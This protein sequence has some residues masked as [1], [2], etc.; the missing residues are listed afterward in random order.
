MTTHQRIIKLVESYEAMGEHFYQLNKMLC[1]LATDVYGEGY[2]SP[3][4]FLEFKRLMTETN[5]IQ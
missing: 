4:A 3:E 1:Q 5:E 2:A